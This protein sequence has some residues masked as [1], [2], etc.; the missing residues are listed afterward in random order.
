MS[1]FIQYPLKGNFLYG[2]NPY[3]ICANPYSFAKKN[4]LSWVKFIW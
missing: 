2:D 4:L 3:L 1:F